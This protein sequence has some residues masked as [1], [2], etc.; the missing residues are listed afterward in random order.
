MRLGEQ[1]SLTFREI[2]GGGDLAERDVKLSCAEL[3][4]SS[5][6]VRTREAIGVSLKVR[7]HGGKFSRNP[8]VHR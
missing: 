3:S 2:G 7:D 8:F 6:G 5:F 1:T 4:L